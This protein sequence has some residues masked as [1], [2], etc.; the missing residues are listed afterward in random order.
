MVRGS[1]GSC[2]CW[3]T[4]ANADLRAK[5]G[6][7][8]GT[9]PDG[10]LG[11][12]GQRVWALAA[13]Q[14]CALNSRSMAAK[15]SPAKAKKKKPP[16]KRSVRSSSPFDDFKRLA[17]LA[18]GGKKWVI[19][20][21]DLIELLDG[22]KTLVQRMLEA[23]RNGDPWLSLVSNVR[24]TGNRTVIDLSSAIAAYRRILDGEQPPHMRSERNRKAG[25]KKIQLTKF[26]EPDSVG[27]KFMQI[28]DL[29]P[30][31]TAKASFDIKSKTFTVDWAD[32]DYQAFRMRSAR[33][34]RRKLLK[35]S[36]D[37]HSKAPSS[38]A[39]D[40]DPCSDWVEDVV[41]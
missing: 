31:G 1:G 20:K 21:K 15:K 19:D 11:A 13:R 6:H 32:G 24:G 25:I 17:T 12:R 26:G 8:Q 34:E 4:L 10:K 16:T 2:K 14:C 33:G 27:R 23:T 9:K 35:I 22:Q 36:F 28:L 41:D 3:Q 38:S 30:A 39:Q 29:L 5:T 37:R 40:D 18:S 7:K